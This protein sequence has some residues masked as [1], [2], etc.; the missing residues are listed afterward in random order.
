MLLKSQ[1]GQKLKSQYN[2]CNLNYQTHNSYPE[3]KFS[4]TFQRNNTVVYL[5]TRGT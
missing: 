1:Y 2:V 4:S 5:K 3:Q